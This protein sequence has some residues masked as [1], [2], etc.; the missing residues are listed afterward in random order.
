MDNIAK[1][2]Q[3]L[4]VLKNLEERS[5]KGILPAEECSRTAGQIIIDIE[6]ELP[7]ESA[8]LHMHRRFIRNT[9]WW[10]TP[11]SGY[12]EEGH[13]KNL[14]A[15]QEH[16][17]GLLT[18]LQ[19]SFL[20]HKLNEEQYYFSQ[21]QTFEAQK[22]IF[23]LMKR[24]SKSL[25]I[26]DPYLD[27]TIFDYVDSLSGQV[28]LQLLTSTKKPIFPKLLMAF[29]K[30]RPSAEARECSDCHDRFIIID[31][32]EIW[33]LGSSINH[34]GESA[35]MINKVEVASDQY[36]QLMADFQDWW[37]KGSVI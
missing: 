30:K 5:V 9:M 15:I 37:Q 13:I 11:K 35:T 22:K 10:S 36:N 23:E 7:P 8:T 27:D 21:G 19:P 14:R 26:I 18:E 28:E 4:D 33:Q 20:G 12:A 32:V 25:A 17:G 29:Q 34:L 24:A 3:H 16:I 6:N 1:L 2:E 31:N